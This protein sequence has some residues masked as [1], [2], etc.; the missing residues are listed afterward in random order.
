MPCAPRKQQDAEPICV[1][2]ADGAPWPIDDLDKMSPRREHKQHSN[3]FGFARRQHLTGTD[4]STGGVT[5]S[6]LGCRTYRSSG[7]SLRVKRKGGNVFLVLASTRTP[8]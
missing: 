2:S 1:A 7:L 6:S 8:P 4:N 3:M 5:D